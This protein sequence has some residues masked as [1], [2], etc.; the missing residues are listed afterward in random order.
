MTENWKFLAGKSFSIENLHQPVS[1]S[2]RSGS[3]EYVTASSTHTLALDLAQPQS[4]DGLVSFEYTFTEE[5][6]LTFH[7]RLENLAEGPLR[8]EKLTL[9]VTN[10][11]LGSQKGRLSVFKQGYQS[12]TETRRFSS[13][14]REIHSFLTPMTIMQA[15][16][17]NLSTGKPGEITS[18]M[19]SVIGDPD[20]KLFVLAGQLRPFDHFFYIN[21]QTNPSPAVELVFDLGGKTLPPHGA[22]QLDPFVLLV[23]SHANRILERYLELIASP[24]AVQ[25]E[26]PVGWCSWYYYYTKVT[27]ADLTENLAEIARRKV[28]WQFFVLDDGY[29]TAVGD[30]LALNAKFP[31]GLKAFTENC[32]S[33]GI[34]PGIWLAPFIART[35]SRLFHEHRDW[36]LKDSK[37]HPALAGWNPGWGLEGRFYGLDTT[38]PGF[39]EYLRMVIYTLVH[40]WG[41]EYLKLDFTYGASLYGAAC[42]TSL[43]PAERLKLGYRLIREAA[44]PDVFILGCGSP[45]TPAIGAVDAMRIG[46]DVAPYWFDPIRVQLTRDPN[47][48]C[49]KVAIRNILTRA[50]FHRRLWINDPDCLLL[51]DTDTQLNAHERL[52]LVNAIVITGGMLILSDR[53]TALRDE[54][55]QSLAAIRDLVQRCDR[56][57][58]WPLDYMERAMPEI[59]YNSTGFL[60]V[61]NFADH[62][63]RK[64]VDFSRYLAL[65]DTELPLDEIWS[66]KK[67][68][69]KNGMLDFGEMPP[70]SSLLL[71]FP[72]DLTV[73]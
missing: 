10:I 35:N 64:Q 71:P 57:R 14:E 68:L 51:R 1:F 49:A 22:L 2:G 66:R 17:R 39:Q 62:P 58:A 13:D 25:K 56:G 21:A 72:K 33:Q 67:Y 11:H 54:Q 24:A 44:G 50:Q 9:A 4:S 48:V 65:S 30:W 46:E 55:W 29:E 15:N 27:Q 5:P 6:E 16:P 37:G 59:V 32:R 73:S 47:A 34:Q 61:F 69:L 8:I 36:F 20:L 38:N 52:T 60:A 23:D 12:W 43:S 26:L 3:L 7:G 70:H 45:L 40:E 31:G 42:D 19:F 53:L 41:F 28:D 18:E 63:V